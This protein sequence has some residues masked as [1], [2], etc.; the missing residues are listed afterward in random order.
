MW[1]KIIIFFAENQ[2]I[3]LFL[4]EIRVFLCALTQKRHSRLIARMPLLAI[5]SKL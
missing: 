2:E 3:F 5:N 1:C 4:Y